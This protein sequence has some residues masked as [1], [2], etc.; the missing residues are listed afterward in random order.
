MLP[1]AR[2]DRAAGLARSL[3]VTVDGHCV[4]ALTGTFALL[5]ESHPQGAALAPVR[6]TL[7]AAAR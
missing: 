7:E 1:P 4:F 3:V 5:G 2:A 6:E